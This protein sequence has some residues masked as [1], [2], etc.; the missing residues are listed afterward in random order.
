MLASDPL[1]G[2]LTLRTPG[3]DSPALRLALGRGLADSEVTPRRLAPREI[4]VLRRLS[5]RLPVGLVA[6]DAGRADSRRRAG[7]PAARAE[8]G[9]AAEPRL[10]ADL[11]AETERARAAA[12]RPRDGRVPADA[13]A[14][15]FAD[16]AEL[17]ACL[18]LDLAAGA[19]ARHWWWAA[20]LPRL[21][22][23]ARSRL[24]ALLASD[25]LELPGAVVLLHRWGRDAEVLGALSEAESL[26]LTDLVLRT[27]PARA[28]RGWEDGGTPRDGMA[29]ALAASSRASGEGAGS[30]PAT[31]PDQG[32][33]RE[34]VAA[35]GPPAGGAGDPLATARL[36][37]AARR[38]L[39]LCLA[40]AGDGG[41]R[42]SAVASL[43][44]A[45]ADS[46]RDWASTDPPPPASPAALGPPAHDNLALVAASA[47]SRRAA[48]R[49]PNAHVDSGLAPVVGPHPSRPVRG[50]HS[51][52]ASPELSAEPRLALPGPPSG[53]DAFDPAKTGL[54]AVATPS[55]VVLR[56]PSSP[57]PTLAVATPGI[58]PAASQ[59]PWD[60]TDGVPTT[61]GGV[62]YLI[63]LLRAL[64][65][66]HGH[67]ADLGSPAGLG[68]WG[69]VEVLGRALAGDPGAPAD[70]IWALLA[71]LD[72]REAGR[73]PTATLPAGARF[74][75]PA[76]W[77]ADL[78]D[79]G[80]TTGWWTRD[81][82][83]VAW[84][85]PLPVLD[86]PDPGS[87][88][89][90]RAALAGWG[91]AGPASGRYPPPLP[92]LPPALAELGP[93][94]ALWLRRLLPALGLR[95]AQALGIA[96]GDAA[97]LADCLLVCPG[98]LYLT[99]THLD[100]VAGLDAI[101]LP[102]RRAG[103]DRDPGWLPEVGRVVTF[104]YR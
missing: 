62:L 47:R 97:G 101:S 8:R 4:L 13:Q 15:L 28:D 85:G 71:L 25:P 103:V 60:W 16:E 83:L 69:M 87:D 11:G 50:L 22:P 93:D 5:G 14:V 2:R 36:S 37:P 19:A 78:A 57:G 45:P 80:A 21:D 49:R 74:R 75:L 94:L 86:V 35:A 27:F 39:R 26:G 51:A 17:I 12:V 55:E 41:P 18:A 20:V 82:R 10:L 61:L 32:A 7:I 89:A 96:P 95:L 9:G 23:A 104:H 88:G 46:T 73:L 70:P 66:P 6:G 72:G 68:P 90:R 30:T 54:A 84:C 77:R 64:D 98:T 91:A 1:V 3:G 63:N 29:A 34:G 59:T 24:A 48:T 92:G 38:L 52:G 102:V 56:E 67:P 33:M 53:P 44:P 76:A 43:S 99:R 100:L 40:V 42:A 79:G 81:G 65:L 31:A 58:A